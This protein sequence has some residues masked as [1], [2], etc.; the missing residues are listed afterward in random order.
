[1]HALSIPSHLNFE[2]CRLPDFSWWG[3]RC[4]EKFIDVTGRTYIHLSA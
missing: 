2:N 4:R 3:S 1:M